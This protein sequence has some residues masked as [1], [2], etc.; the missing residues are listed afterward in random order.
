VTIDLPTEDE[1]VKVIEGDCLDV[2][3]TLPDG[4]VDAIVTDPPFGIGFKYATHDDTA[5]GYGA[6]LWSTLA[7]AERTCSPGSPL[8]VWQAMPNVRR[9]AE[10]FPRDWRLFA[11]AKN[12]VQIRPHAM[13]N[14]FD[15]VV[16]WWTD[17]ERWNAKDGLT[18]R[19]W[20]IAN[21]V[22]TA[23]T[24]RAAE[25]AHPCPRPLDQVKYIVRNWCRPN[26]IVLDCFG[27]SGT[28]AVAALHEGRRCLIVEKDAGYCDIIRRRVAEA[29]GV[30]KGS[31]L[32]PS[33]GLF[34][35]VEGVA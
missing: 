34:D 35:G 15:P 17:G 5:E 32:A 12:F 11:A 30:G 27:G 2:L 16:V 10:W 6:W 24:G 9:F 20:H 18:A 25:R 7:E 23:R 33:A 3:R 28:T 1:P 4:C 13:Q 14:A 26:G 19:D 31:L 21:T 8:F 29:M 22:P